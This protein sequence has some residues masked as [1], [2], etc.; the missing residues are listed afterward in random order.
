MGRITCTKIPTVTHHVGLSI[1]LDQDS[2]TNEL[3]SRYLVLMLQVY[4]FNSLTRNAT[5][6]SGKFVRDAVGPPTHAHTDAANATPNRFYYMFYF[7]IFFK[8]PSWALPP[9]S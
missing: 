8:F 4:T 3:I 7:Q 1:V 9:L 6:T 2:Y 5:G